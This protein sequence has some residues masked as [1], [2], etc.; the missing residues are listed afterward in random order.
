MLAGGRGSRMGVPKADLLFRGEPL[1]ARVVDALSAVASFVHV[2]LGPDQELSVA[3]PSSVTIVRDATRGEG[4]VAGLAAGLRASEGERA[5][6]VG[7]DMP[8]LDAGLLRWLVAQAGGVDVVIPMVDDRPQY[9]HS[10]FRT[11]T[12]GA[13]ER[14]FARGVRSLAGI[15]EGLTAHYVFPPEASMRSFT[16]VNTTDDL[17]RAESL[18]DARPRVD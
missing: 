18:I 6:V 10:V 9:L 5:I 11:A 16:N 3:L 7:C 2:V 12:H 8:F 13:I 15:V 17:R 1:L 4:P 14:S